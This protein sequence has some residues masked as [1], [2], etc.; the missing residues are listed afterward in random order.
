MMRIRRGRGRGVL[1]AL[2]MALTLPL[3]GPLVAGAAAPPSC[4]S[5]QLAARVGVPQGAAGTIFYPLVLTNRGATCVLWGLPHVQPV[6]RAPHRPVGPPA[7]N[8]SVGQFPARHTLVHGA[9][10]ASAFGVSEVGNYPPARCR[11]APASGVVVS[12]APFLTP[13]YLALRIAVCTRV[14]STSIRLP[15]PGVTGA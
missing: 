12:L 1:A 8:A 6:G 11:A 15:V 7:R 2:V 5:A 4:R 13:R 14:A 3:A 9:S 10:V